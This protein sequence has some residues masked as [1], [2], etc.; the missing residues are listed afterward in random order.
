VCTVSSISAQELVRSN[1]I[2]KRLAIADTIIL[3]SL[4]IEPN[5]IHINMV[6]DASFIYSY[7]L[8]ALTWIT[9]PQLDSIDITYRLLN[10]DLQKVQ[11]RKDRSRVAMGFG[12]EYDFNALTQTNPDKFVEY[13]G[14]DYNGSL[15]RGLSFGNAQ[16]A[17]L[18]SQ[19]NLQMKG[20][21]ADSVEI[22]A[23][24]TDNNIPFQPQG[25]T[26]RLQEFDRI[27][28]NLSKRKALLQLGDYDIQRPD[29]YFMQFYKRVQGAYFSNVSNYNKHIK[30]K[31]GGGASLAKGKFV[32]NALSVAEG[33]QGPYKLI[34]PAGETFF[35]ILA[36]SERI[37]VDGVI[38]QRGEDNDYVIDYNTA[39][40]TFMPRCMIHK[41]RRVIVEYEYN[42]R[43]YLNSLIY[44]THQVDIG[45]KWQ[46]RGNFYSNQDAPNQP[47]QQELDSTQKILLASVG[48]DVNRAYSISAVRDSTLAG[49]V[50]YELKDTIIGGTFYDSVFVFTAT[51]TQSSLS[52]NFS[53]VGDGNGDY[54]ISNNS[55]NGRV[56]EFMPPI[57]GQKQGSFVPYTLLI[58]PKR[59]QM[60]TAGLS[61]KADSNTN[62]TIEMALSNNDP[63]LFSSIGNNTHLGTAAK[64]DAMH[65]RFIGKQKQWQLNGML[66]Y[67]FVESRFKP[68]ERFRT[69][70][71][72][73]DWTLDFLPTQTNEHIGKAM[74]GISK[75][76]IFNFSYEIN[77]FLR[78]KEFNGLRH[79]VSITGNKNGL[80]YGATYNQTEAATSTYKASFYRPLV[81]AEYAIK[82]LYNSKVGIRCSTENNTSKLLNTDNLAPNTFA[83]NVAQAW[84]QNAAD[85]TNK[86]NF[87]YTLREDQLAKNNKLTAATLAHNFTS[88]IELNSIEHHTIRAN[89]TYRNLLVKDT[90]LYKQKSEQSMLGRLEYA[91]AYLNNAISINT[92]YEF[93]NGQE[94]RREYAYV[95]VAAGKGEFAWIDY[96]SDGIQQL[97]EFEIAQFPDQRRFIRVFTPST[98]YMKVNYSSANA[99]LNI[100]PKQYFKQSTKQFAKLVGR[101]SN[102]T[103]V[104]L[105]TRT[106]AGEQAVQLM[107]WYTPPNDT[108]LLAQNNSF[109]NNLFFN[110]LSSVWGLDYVYQQTVT[111]N[112]LTYGID[113]RNS[114]EHIL[115]LRYNIT[116]QLSLLSN[117]KIGDRLFDSKFLEG[118]SYH[119][120]FIS[121][122]PSLALLSKNANDRIT[123]G[124]KFEERKNRPQ[125]GNELSITNSI[126]LEYKHT[127]ANSGTL[128]TKFTYSSLAYNAAANNSIA[129][130]MLDGLLPG[131]N[132]IWQLSLDRRLGKGFE[133]GIGYD[134]RKSGTNAAVHTGRATARAIF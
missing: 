17:V 98:N 61:Y 37:I 55:I 8:K 71:F 110:R 23:A 64:L 129:F 91:A 122:E 131:R 35:I 79:V 54:R 118:R 68:L 85:A 41:D 84:W 116:R 96:N 78:T 21:V 128:Q 10:L 80:Q 97:N 93:G 112:L 29:G 22:S 133:I 11:Q 75:Q 39:E 76:T 74:L 5:S 66:G 12:Y 27:Y 18:N 132:F 38:M 70:E 67:E 77:T 43:Y 134:G 9:K 126:N 36:N 102:I 120:D 117:G 30:H 26:Q 33:N 3:D 62:I 14:I 92:L 44:T 90:F 42:D 124:Y 105:S 15:S 130:I 53:F 32:R 59:L 104:Q 94:L 24:I 72:T 81:Y 109:V 127:S 16:D 57:N 6:K 63:N 1:L 60:Y 107:P 52:V 28:I 65:K 73:R 100:N 47:F 99:S 46:V 101:F 7:K 48:D 121:A 69:T 4:T 40:L 31:Y 20:Y 114:T 103:N 108:S 89:I 2:S 113:S 95:E 82:K 34:G 88:A 51:R 58:A 19:F 25:N 125:F 13:D 86:Y 111:K 49:K 106:M 56:Y 115:R 83:F 87:N 45:N 123:C 50:F 119:F